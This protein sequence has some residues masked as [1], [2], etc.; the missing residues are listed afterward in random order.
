MQHPISKDDVSGSQSGAPQE[1]EK[2][3]RLPIRER[4]RIWDSENLDEAK[5]ILN[6]SAEAGELSNSFTRPQN[7]TM[8]TFAVASP[9]FDGDELGDL[10]SD[11]ANLKPGDMVELGYVYSL[12]KPF[13][14]METLT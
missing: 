3:K 6:D 2:E 10:R 13:P 11:D 14:P 9:L 12:S 5:S 7:V 1:E 4:L 8:A